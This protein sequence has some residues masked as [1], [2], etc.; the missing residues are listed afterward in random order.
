MKQ[1]ELIEKAALLH[2]IGKVYQR[3]THIRKNHSLVGKEVLMPYFSDGYEEILR[4]VKNH[5]RTEL[6][7]LKG[8]DN[9]ISYLIYEAD[10][11]AA[12]SDR[13]TSVPE[14]VEDKSSGMRFIPTTPLHNIFNVFDRQGTIGN[15][16][17][18]LRGMDAE[19]KML[20]P[21]LQEKTQAPS[22]MY[23]KITRELDLSFKQRSPAEMTINELLQLLEA[24][25]TYIPSS[26]NTNEVP[27]IS[28]YDHQKLTA[29]FAACMY[30]FFEERG[31]TDYKRYCY[32][33]K[34]AAMR[35]APV[36]VL[37]SGDMSGIQKFIYTIP[38]KGALKSLR[39]RSLYLDLLL[40]N[41]VDELLDACGVSRSCLLYTGGG[42]FFM[43]LP[44]TKKAQDILRDYTINLNEWFLRHYG[45]RLYMALAYT[46]CSAM[47]FST[48]GGGAGNVFRTVSHTLSQEK[49]CRYMEEQL[50][51]M[52]SPQSMY[53]KIA[54]D[55]R[56][57]AIC[58]ASTSAAE[59]Q[60]YG[61]ANVKDE[62]EPEQ[63]C[64][65][66][67]SLYRLGQRALQGSIFCVRTE[68]S[69][70][71][72]PIPGYGEDLYLTAIS[73]DQLKQSVAP[74]RLYIKNELTLGNEVATHLWM[75]DYITKNAEGHPLEF[76]E[77]AQRS[78]GDTESS[79]IERIGILRADVDDLGT[80]FIKGF[81]SR[82]DTLS[83]KAAL[84]RNLSL[85]FK[86]YINDL[87][88]GYTADA[89]PGF[90][91]FQDEVKTTRQVHII[92][93]GGDDMFLAGAWD[94]IIEVAID[95]RHAFQ[96]FTNGKLTF[97]AGVGFFHPDCPISQMARKTG[98]LEEYAK[99]NPQKN[100][101]ALFGEV[102]K[103]NACTED[104]Q[105]ARYTW[106]EFETNVCGEKLEFLQN[107]FVMN[108]EMAQNKL[109]IG[110]GAIY[111]LLGLMR[112]SAQDAGHI[113]LAR[114]AYTLARME[115]SHSDRIKKQCYE[116]VRKQ[117]YEWYQS[118]TDCQQLMTAIELWVY[119]LRDKGVW[120][121]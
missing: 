68:K 104:Q 97:S 69:A 49:L 112:K 34:N 71:A 64:R 100:S 77:L 23:Q 8:P 80:A 109:S 95:L 85:F 36:Y 108:G 17:Y 32:G 26:T 120:D 35:K 3:A 59:L 19:E 40:E 60:P 72:V 11:L 2:D 39:G 106:D 92:Y 58:H 28:L 89:K 74:K 50:Q 42:H 65:A 98:D 84:S 21:G 43:L 57:C 67:N 45:S 83:R 118:E 86:R 70:E 82:Y 121:K 53:N 47:D 30:R 117:L 52:F 46:P 75:G 99:D 90:T 41:I 94:D 9:D 103:Y 37:V 101:I 73:E 18:H 102:V 116:E 22:A 20:Y 44:N 10:N 113:N 6:E 7:Q 96:H 81:A 107:H 56:E 111:R 33:N 91:L 105:T 66:C 119:R 13:R 14:G 62:E 38:S 87:C 12:A 76:K 4:A 78:G 93:S 55:K 27:D 5:H 79:G 88:Q 115:P 16:A 15:T 114:F 48:N 54:D 25:M 1:E 61:D 51:K 31:I 24:T 110:K 29:A 63:A